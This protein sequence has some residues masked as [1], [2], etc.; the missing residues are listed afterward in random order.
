MAASGGGPE[1]PHR[2]VCKTMNCKCCTSVSREARAECRRLSIPYRCSRCL[3]EFLMPKIERS[4]RARLRP[5]RQKK[6]R[7]LRLV[8]SLTPRQLELYESWKSRCVNLGVPIT[9]DEKFSYLSD[10]LAA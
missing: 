7:L 10:L 8:E 1:A 6:S 2:P 4:R 9:P 3:C 5:K